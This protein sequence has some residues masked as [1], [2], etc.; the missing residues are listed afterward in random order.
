MIWY[1]ILGQTLNVL[2]YSRKKANKGGGVLRIYFFQPLSKIE[3]IVISRNNYK[4]KMAACRGQS[5]HIICY[6]T[7]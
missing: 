5:T 6:I 4:Q 3:H 2:G 1:N 7:W